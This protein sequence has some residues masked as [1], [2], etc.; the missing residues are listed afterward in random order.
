M[1]TT[2][3]AGQPSWHLVSDRTEAWLT[4]IGGHLG[5]ISFNLDGRVVSPFNLAPWAEETFE[6]EL[7]P[8]LRVLRGDFFCL[9]FGGNDVPFGSERHPPHG[10]T[11]NRKWTFESL[12]N[13]DGRTTLHASMETEIRPGR[14]DKYISLREGESAVYQRHRVSRMTG[15]MSF[16]HHCMLK[17]PDEDGSGLISTSAFVLGRTAP[18][19]VELPRNQ[20][21]SLLRPDVGFDSLESVETVTGERANLSRYPARRGYEDL[22]MLVSDPA[23]SLA[24]TAVSFPEEGYA[25]FALKNPGVLRNTVFW[26]SNMGRY[27][28]PWNGRHLNVMGL[29]E[30]TSYF[31]YGLAESATDNPISRA[32]YPTCENL[33]GNEVLDVRYI[34]G[35]VATGNGFGRVADIRPAANGEAVLIRGTGGE[36]VFAAVDAG[37]LQARED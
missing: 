9:P 21:Y 7:P 16:G 25:W 35:V 37:F 6:P 19:P 3:I 23:L 8:I 12:S 33:N 5:P 13:S 27:Y 31:H 20:G 22:V 29:E 26:M 28:A 30:V 11:A 24:W 32:G 4:E 18:L 34:I 2:R 14:V 36:T 10:E 1:D 15:P 17:F